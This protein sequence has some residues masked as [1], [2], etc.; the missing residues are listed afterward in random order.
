MTETEFLKRVEGVNLSDQEKAILRKH[1]G[2]PFDKK[3]IPSHQVLEARAL[4][5]AANKL[6]EHKTS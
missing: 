4:L 5:F 6:P 3:L 2:L 1:F